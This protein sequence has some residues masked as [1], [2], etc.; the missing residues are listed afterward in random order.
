MCIEIIDNFV[1]YFNCFF[2]EIGLKLPISQN[3]V[4]TGLFIFHLSYKPH[5]EHRVF[6]RETNGKLLSYVLQFLRKS[7]FFRFEQLTNSDY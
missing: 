5:N 1:A 3:S 4:N 6:G 2:I 7:F